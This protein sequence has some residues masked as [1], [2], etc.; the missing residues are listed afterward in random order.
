[1]INKLYSVYDKQAQVYS[2]PFSAV[3]DA[4]AQRI[5]KGTLQEA[6]DNKLSIWPDDFALYRMAEFDDSKNIVGYENPVHV[7]EVGQLQRE[8]VAKQD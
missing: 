1:M 5:V 2:A 8:M 6:G 7:I 4:I 3:N